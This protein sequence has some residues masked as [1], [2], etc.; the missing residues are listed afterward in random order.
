MEKELG[1]PHELILV[2]T[3]RAR[4]VLKGRYLKRTKIISLL[5]LRI[6][7]DFQSKNK[8]EVDQKDDVN[9]RIL[10]AI[11]KNSKFTINLY[12]EHQNQLNE[13]IIQYKERETTP[14]FDS[15]KEFVQESIFIHILFSE[16]KGRKLIENKTIREL[17]SIFSSDPQLIG[18]IKSLEV[19]DKRSINGDEVNDIINKIH[20][21][22]ETPL[23]E[24]SM[25]LTFNLAAQF[26]NYK[27][28]FLFEH[29]N[30]VRKS[31]QELG[32]VVDSIKLDDIVLE[33]LFITSI[34]LYLCGY[35]NALRLPHEEKL[36]YFE[37][38]I[39]IPT[40]LSEFKKAFDKHAV[41]DLKYFKIPLWFV[42][43]IGIVF[44]C[45]SV[46]NE[47]YLP[48]QLNLL[49]ISVPLPFNVPIFAIISAGLFI[50]ITYQLYKLKNLL[51]KELRRG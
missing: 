38:I 47:I 29:Y 5:L 17:F 48:S 4:A 31:T 15:L 39:S 24:V 11:A 26:D 46:V 1:Y 12:K 33:K 36:N 2:A 34:I 45:L 16:F 30:L 14:A 43:V 19:L 50:F 8:T 9:L 32:G 21:V 42:G 13:L 51:L 49:I 23:L 27:S 41:L 44:M 10:N 18:S 6:I 37:H 28:K 3:K 25:Y 20:S 40:I 22:D 35:K 7:E